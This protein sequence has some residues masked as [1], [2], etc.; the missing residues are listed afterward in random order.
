MKFPTPEARHPGYLGKRFGNLQVRLKLVILHN[1]FFLLLTGSVYFTVFPLLEQRVA[2]AK[3]REISLIQQE[4]MA[5]SSL[6][7]LP[8]LEIYSYKEGSAQVL[9]L[10]PE[11]RNWLDEHPGKLLGDPSTDEY[12]FRKTVATSTYRKIRL[13]NEYYQQAIEHV[14]YA[15]FAVLGVIYVLAVLV[16][17]SM[18]MPLYVYRPL[19]AMLKA[20]RASRAG[21]RANEIIPADEILAD[22]IGQIMRSRN[23]TVREL[24][25]REDQLEKAKQSLAAQNRRA[26]LGRLSAR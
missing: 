9:G 17:E 2:G 10:S 13:P 11:I 15:V 23:H 18:I 5:D 22:E 14:R 25:H 4:F 21:D 12:L 26:S 7:M 24:R 16:L 19:R 6:P 20:D 8:S 3:A 1:L